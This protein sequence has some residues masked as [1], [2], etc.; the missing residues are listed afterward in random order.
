[1]T[2]RPGHTPRRPTVAALRS[3]AIITATVVTW[4]ALPAPLSAQATTLNT[5]HGLWG[6]GNANTSAHWSSLIKAMQAPFAAV[7]SYHPLSGSTIPNWI[8]REAA[9][10]H[11]LLY[12]NINSWRVVNGAKVCYPWWKV[13]AGLQDRQLGTLVRQLKGFHYSRIVLSFHH[14][15]NVNVRNEP[16]C[17]TPRAYGQAFAHVVTYFRAHGIRYPWVWTMTASAFSTGKATAYRPPLGDISFV[18]TDGYNMNR[19]GVW[20][21]PQ[22]VFGAAIKYAAAIGRPLFVGEIGCV[23]RPGNPA[24]K[25]QWITTAAQMLAASGVTA[26]L[27][28]DQIEYTPFTSP[29][30]EAAWVAAS[31]LPYYQ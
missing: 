14:E 21:S 19:G 20:R 24:A 16:S 26:L 7:G 18:G 25:A 28:D 4:A 3:M 22:V 11:A 31:R 9:S 2:R 8:D 12:L 10:T 5:A 29:Q 15:P 23:E 1:M 13:A 17:G 6:I 27:W 30:A